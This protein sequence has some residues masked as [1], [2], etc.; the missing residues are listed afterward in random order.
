MNW[1]DIY[2]FAGTIFTFLAFIGWLFHYRFFYETLY[3]L[4]LNI[5]PKKFREKFGKDMLCDFCQKCTERKEYA[6]GLAVVWLLIKEFSNVSYHSVLMNI[7]YAKRKIIKLLNSYSSLSPLEKVEV[8]IKFAF[9]STATSLIAAVSL[10]LVFVYY[11]QNIADEHTII[12]G[13]GPIYTGG[14]TE[15]G[16]YLFLLLIMLI[17]LFIAISA[18]IQFIRASGDG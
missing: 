11:G 2:Y 4:I 17:S 13:S 18:A 9:Y 3:K 10:V 1:L 15:T 6:S 16:I 14:K 8:A 5:Y 12:T 7:E